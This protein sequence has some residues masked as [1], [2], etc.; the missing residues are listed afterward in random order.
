MVRVFLCFYSVSECLRVGEFCLSLVMIFM[1]LLWVVL[2]DSVFMGMLF[3]VFIFLF[4]VVC[5]GF[6]V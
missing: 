4:Y 6:L 1:S 2:N 3:M 5:C